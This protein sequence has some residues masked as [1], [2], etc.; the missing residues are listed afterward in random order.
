[1]DYN[2]EIFMLYDRQVQQSYRLLRDGEVSL[3]VMS[4]DRLLICDRVIAV[5]Y[6]NLSRLLGC[7]WSLHVTVTLL[8]TGHMA[9][10]SLVGYRNKLIV[11]TLP[12]TILRLIAEFLAENHHQH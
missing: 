2:C 9:T 7:C 3:Q 5:H 1:M 12:I 10:C 6:G 11:H 8:S 4:G